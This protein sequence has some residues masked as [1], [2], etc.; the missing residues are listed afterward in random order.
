MRGASVVTSSVRAVQLTAQTPNDYNYDE[1]GEIEWVKGEEVLHV[2]STTSSA[3]PSSVVIKQE[4][5]DAI[6]PQ[7]T[8]SVP[9]SHQH[10]VNEEDTDTCPHFSLRMESMKTFF[11]VVSALYDAKK[12][13]IATIVVNKRG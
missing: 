1:D 9:T 4:S 8:A 7:S 10:A 11:S 6:V 13:Q 5:P 3:V 2:G 12:D